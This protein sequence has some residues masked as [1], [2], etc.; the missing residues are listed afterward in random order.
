MPTAVK[1]LTEEEFGD[2]EIHDIYSMVISKAVVLLENT[3]I[4]T[5][6][7]GGPAASHWSSFFICNHSD[8]HSVC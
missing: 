1:L 2:A 8:Q 5:E 4:C 3:I 6:C 7:I